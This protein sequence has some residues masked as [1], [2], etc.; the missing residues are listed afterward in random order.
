MNTNQRKTL[1]LR[2]NVCCAQNDDALS[3]NSKTKSMQLLRKKHSQQFCL[4]RRKNFFYK[5]YKGSFETEFH[6]HQS[7]AIC[8]MQ[9]ELNDVIDLACTVRSSRLLL[10]R[11]LLCLVG[12]LS[13]CNLHLHLFFR[14]FRRLCLPLDVVLR[15]PTNTKLS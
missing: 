10:G 12:F 13:G 2:R 9:L 15:N 1:R 5:K 11:L 7:R 14:L 3:E 6:P 8:S 4:E